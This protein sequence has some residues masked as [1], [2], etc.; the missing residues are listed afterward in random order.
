MRQSEVIKTI[1]GLLLLAGSGCIQ[2]LKP[3][4]AA[5]VCV[6]EYVPPF[7]DYSFEYAPNGQAITFPSFNSPPKELL[8]V[9]QPVPARVCVSGG[10]SNAIST[11][12]KS[13]AGKKKSIQIRESSCTDFFVPAVEI[14]GGCISS[15]LLCN[16]ISRTWHCRDNVPNGNPIS[17]PF[18]SRGWWLVAS[19]PGTS[20]TLK[21]SGRALVAFAFNPEKT[22][23]PHYFLMSEELK[24][25][26]VCVTGK[27]TIHMSKDTFGSTD[28]AQK[29]LTNTCDTLQGRALW[30]V[31]EEINGGAP[32]S[33]SFTYAVTW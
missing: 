9:F 23:P 29:T 18:W 27:A 8:N 13:V 6:R 21:A 16:V 17:D 22:I 3:Q 7:Y 2:N 24:T 14:Q 33:A 12:L 25:V 15:N 26:K 20:T 1:L 31:P 28:D 5:P 32:G 19:N 11:A 10:P 4:A 30:V